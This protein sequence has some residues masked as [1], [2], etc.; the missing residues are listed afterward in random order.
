M[1]KEV[2]EGIFDGERGDAGPVE[3]GPGTRCRSGS[4]NRTQDRRRR[5]RRK[6]AMGK[7]PGADGDPLLWPGTQVAEVDALFAIAMIAPGLPAKARALGEP[8]ELSGAAEPLAVHAPCV[9]TG[10]TSWY[11]PPLRI[12][13]RSSRARSRAINAA[14]GAGL[15]TAWTNLRRDYEGDDDGDHAD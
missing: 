6:E 13:P 1:A 2:V 9:A 15:I 3:T 5:R 10:G 4:L 7:E 12:Q 11:R 14:R 8:S